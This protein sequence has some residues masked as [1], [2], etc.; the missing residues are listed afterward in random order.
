[1]S[2]MG[3]AHTDLSTDHE[4]GQFDHEVLFKLGFRMFFTQS[5]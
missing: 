1:M 2:S 3:T 4:I 5:D